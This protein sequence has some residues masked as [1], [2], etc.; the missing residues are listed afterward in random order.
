MMKAEEV[1]TPGPGLTAPRRLLGQSLDTEKIPLEFP[2]AAQTVDRFHVV[3]LFTHAMDE[4]RR[5]EA[6][7]ERMPKGTR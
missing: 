4:A 6:R 3:Q 5:V 2:N 1:F 7:K